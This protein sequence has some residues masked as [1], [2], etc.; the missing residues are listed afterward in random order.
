MRTDVVHD[1][2]CIVAWCR[3]Q[4]P[5]PLGGLGVV[6]LKVRCQVLQI[7]WLWLEHT[8][9]DLPWVAIRGKTNAT[10]A[11]F[12]RAST[13]WLLG[14]GNSILFWSSLWLDD[15]SIEELAP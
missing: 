1:G 9:L 5:L 12:F 8:Q 3:V 7:H 10:V 6:D 15:Q 4:R 14:D 13:C 11:A 2:K